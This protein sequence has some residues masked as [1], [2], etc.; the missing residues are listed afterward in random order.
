VEKDYT[1]TGKWCMFLIDIFLLI[2]L[3]LLLDWQRGISMNLA[4]REKDIATER[5]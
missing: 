1:R 3:P 2:R 4:E 5:K